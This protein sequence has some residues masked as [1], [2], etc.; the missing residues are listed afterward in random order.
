MITVL[1]QNTI[2]LCRLLIYMTGLTV[3]GSL[4]ILMALLEKGCVWLPTLAFSFNTIKR[5]VPHWWGGFNRLLSKTMA[6][7]W[8]VH[9]LK[10]WPQNVS[11]MMICN[12]Q[13]WLDTVVLQSTFSYR[14]PPPIFFFKRPLYWVPVLGW[15]LW[16]C[17]FIPVNRYSPTY[18]QK[19]PEYRGKDLQRTRK[20]CKKYSAQPVTIVNFV[21][22]TR[23]TPKKKDEQGSPYR[24]LLKP[25]AG[26]TAFT[27]AVMR[28]QIKTLLNVTVVY[29]QGKVSFWDY[30]CGRVK[31]IKVY[32]SGLPISRAPMGDYSTDLNFRKDFQQWL[33][34]LWANKDA[35]LL[36]LQAQGSESE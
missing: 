8:Q 13:S 28:E 36:K 16:A 9:G 1:K 7:H 27:L 2:G 23:F 33:N 17:D 12:H 34:R 20:S 32:T 5:K 10:I 35:L 24:C 15:I 26:G 25:R 18:L 3:L 4:L 22:G 21:E 29:P 30:F 11:Y 31:M 19:H 14:L 6:T